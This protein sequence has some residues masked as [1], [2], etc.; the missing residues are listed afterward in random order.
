MD[1]I[2][3]RGL[4]AEAVIG[5][6]DWERKLPRVLIVDLELA[7]DAARAAAKDRIGDA[8][9]YHAVSQAVIAFVAES[10]VQLIETL[11]E[12]LAALLQDKFA[13]R[14]LSLTV[15]KPGA[16][17]AAQDVS[18]TIERGKAGTFSKT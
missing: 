17:A 16:V 1:T 7:A 14:W 4:K 3:I 13:V 11:A 6:H 10:R 8:L 12:Q 15:H 9:D 5:V 18:V 2:R